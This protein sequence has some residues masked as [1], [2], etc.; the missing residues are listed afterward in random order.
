MKF[1]LFALSFITSSMSFAQDSWKVILNGKNILTASIESE[2]K[3]LITITNADLKK[4]QEFNLTYTDQA[5]EKDW[6]RSIM[7]VDENDHE[8][9]QQ[10]GNK[11]KIKNASLQSFFKKSKTLKFYTVSLPT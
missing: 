9:L 10:E 1:F 8:L 2:K 6:Q 11:F 3:N 7:V 5:K 4:K